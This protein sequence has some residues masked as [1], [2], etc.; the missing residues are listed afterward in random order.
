MVYWSITFDIPN[1][2][3]SNTIRIIALT[4]NPKFFNSFS[5]LKSF[6]N[7]FSIIPNISIDAEDDAEDA[8]ARAAHF[9]IP[10]QPQFLPP[11]EFAVELA[12]QAVE[13]GHGD[14]ESDRF[15]VEVGEDDDVGIDDRFHRLHELLRLRLVHRLDARK[16][17]PRLVVDDAEVF[18]RLF[19]IAHVDVFEAVARRGH[20]P[21]GAGEDLT[22]G[23]RIVHTPDVGVLVEVVAEPVMFEQLLVV[24]RIVG[25]GVEGLEFVA[26]DEQS[27]P[28]VARA[29]VDRAVHGLHAAAGQPHARRVEEQVGDLLVVDHLEK[30]A[31][32]GRLL[33]D[34]R[35]FAVVEGGDAPHHLVLAVAYQPA[36]RFAVAEERIAGGIEDLFDILV[37]RAHPVAV[38]FVDAFGQVQEFARQLGRGYLLQ[39]IFRLVRHRERSLYHTKIRISEGN[40]KFIRRLPS[41]SS[42]GAVKNT[43]K[44]GK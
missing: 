1:G 36:N 4:P 16:E 42:F 11:A 34:G 32:A 19:Q 22:V 5:L 17:R 14:E 12:D 15:V 28:R 41:E 23:F 27:P 29:E 18:G 21:F 33:L 26:F 2:S 39:G 43:K 25:V 31:A 9:Q 24:G 37:E 3:A 7:T 6:I 30:A 10:H 35:L 38:A 20:E 8:V 13:V 44:F 40:V